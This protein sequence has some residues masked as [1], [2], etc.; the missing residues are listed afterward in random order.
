[1]IEP[2]AKVLAGTLLYVAVL[3][4]AQRNPR[5]AGMMLTFPTLNG[6]GLL[7]AEPTKVEEA[8]RSMLLMPIL[9]GVLCAGYLAACLRLPRTRLAPAASSLTMTALAMIWL[10]LAWQI[11]S[12]HWGVPSDGQ[13]AYALASAAGGLVL[14]YLLHARQAT[15]YGR[16]VGIRS[17]TPDIASLIVNNRARIALFAL[18]LAGVAVVDRLEGS[19]AMLGVLASLPLVA[20]FGMHAIA[21]DHAMPAQTRRDALAVMATGVWLGPAVAITFVALFWRT[22][23]LLHH[24]GIGFSYLAPAVIALLVGWCLCLLAIWAAAGLLHRM[25]GPRSATRSS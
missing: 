6:I 8:A 7:L 2:A 25:Q 3:W 4:T 9:N 16:E 14:T 24:H 22:L 15:R 20:M 17:V 18:S 11:V 19:P 21:A 23:S 13:A 12:A 10:A 1:M 5:A